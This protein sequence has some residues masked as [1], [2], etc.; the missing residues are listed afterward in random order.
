[1]RGIGVPV[2]LLALASAAAAQDQQL[3]ARTKAMG[4]SYTA[5]EDDPVSVWLNPAG[6]ATQPDQGSISYQTY[7]AYPTATK[8]G[9]ANT[10]TFAVDPE[11]TLAEPAMLPSYLGFVFQLGTAENPMALGFCFARPYLLNYAMD[12]ITSA[13]QTTFEPRNEVKESLSRFRVAFA[14]DFLIQ[15]KG[16]AGFFTHVAVG[17]G[18]DVGYESWEFLT[19]TSDKRDSAVA[20]G[21]GAGLLVGLY[22]NMDT[23]KANLGFAYQS[24]I[25]Y[26]FGID[27]ALLPAFDMPGQMNVGVTFYMLP[28]LPLRATLDLQFIQWKNTAQKSQFA[29]HSG[30]EDVVNYSIGF[31]YRIPASDR[32]SLY[33]RLG[34]RRFDAPWSDKDDL[35][36][37]GS[38]KLVLDT[39]GEAFNI[40][41]FG[42]G[43]SW[44][45]EASKLRSVDIAA[46]AGGDA[47]NV[48]VGYTHEF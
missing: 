36:A 16:E 39:K 12:Q 38:Y 37:T 24:P 33:P 1:M 17:L 6:I 18:L 41:T 22:D 7:T 47:I 28:K 13:N 15:N 14:K 42:L 23:F 27:P 30:F 4:G 8:A 46:D 31:E 40:V 21:L 26:K 29:N 32:I 20:L 44:T 11:L 34:Y 9:P 43:V 35:P 19:P 10:Q 3:G 2:F 45:S 48:A 5:F 25:H